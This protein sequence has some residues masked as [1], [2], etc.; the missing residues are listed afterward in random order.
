[1]V[2]AC[3][4]FRSYIIGS[5]VTI[6][7]DHTVI[8][9]LFAKKDAKSR[10]IRWILLIQEFD[11]EIRDKQGS[12]NTVADHLSRLE[13]ADEEKGTCILKC[14]PDEHLLRV[15]IN[16]PWYA[17]Y[18]NYLA[19]GVFPSDLSYYQRKKFLHDVKSYLWDDSFVFKRCLDQIV[20][21]CM[22]M[23]E[24]PRILNYCHV[25]PCGGH[26]GLT[27]IAAKVL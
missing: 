8:H 19:C 3:D 18:V 6:Y 21:R 22:P 15:E 13:S 26:F 2:F 4:K 1:M 10:L 20:Q 12:E 17:D 24:V 14:F 27:R 5:E 7:T 16:V 25:P 23:E 11:L 9:Y